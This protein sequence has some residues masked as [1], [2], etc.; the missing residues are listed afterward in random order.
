MINRNTGY[1]VNV[2]EGKDDLPTRIEVYSSF[3]NSCETLP[4]AEAEEENHLYLVTKTTGTIVKGRIYKCVKDG[5]TYKWE[6]VSQVLQTQLEGYGIHIDVNGEGNL[7]IGVDKS[8]IRTV[9]ELPADLDD[10][11]KGNTY[12]LTET[13]GDY[14]KGHVYTCIKDGTEYKWKDISHPALYVPG[15]EDFI[16]NAENIRVESDGEYCRIMW[17]DPAD[18]PKTRWSKT[19][20]VKNIYHTPE[21]IDDGVVVVSSTVRNTYSANPFY[22][23]MLEVNPH[24]FYKLFLVGENGLVTN[25]DANMREI[26]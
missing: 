20:L 11:I 9:S 6:D 23:R 26:G 5:S 19:V 1:G 18:A 22:D 21:S 16:S 3:I 8:F 10:T 25:D 17:D 13:A 2:L 12:F 15:P 24:C 7:V 14:I 4:W